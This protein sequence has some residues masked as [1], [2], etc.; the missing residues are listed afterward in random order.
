MAAVY[1]NHLLYLA[2]D[3]LHISTCG[4]VHASAHHITDYMMTVS[5]YVM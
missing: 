4:A 1:A 3:P 2:L 5:Q